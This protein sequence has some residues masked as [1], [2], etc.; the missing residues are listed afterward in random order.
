MFHDL[1]VANFRGR[2][3]KEGPSSY[4]TTKEFET[5]ILLS[6]ESGGNISHASFASLLTSFICNRLMWELIKYNCVCSYP[7][8]SHPHYYSAGTKLKIHQ[9]RHRCESSWKNSE[10][11]MVPV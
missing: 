6:L 7:F 10:I 4:K 1:Q 3:I 9:T 5:L 11:S 8:K 2:D